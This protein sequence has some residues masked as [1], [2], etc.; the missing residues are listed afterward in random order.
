MI[1][2]WYI[3]KS[4]TTYFVNIHIV[5]TQLYTAAAAAACTP[6][7]N[8]DLRYMTPELFELLPSLTRHTSIVNCRRLVVSRINLTNNAFKLL[9]RNKGLNNITKRRRRRWRRHGW[10]GVWAIDCCAVYR[11]FDPR[12]EQIFVWPTGTCSTSGCLC[13][14]FLG[15]RTL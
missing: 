10:R 14:C 15:S 6:K 8:I 1:S 5:R 7:G 13:M 12:T 3:I 2:Y 9:Y 4:F 11:G